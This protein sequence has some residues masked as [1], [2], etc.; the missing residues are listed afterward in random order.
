YGDGS[1]FHWDY[2]N[3]YVIHPMLLDIFRATSGA[4][5]AWAG[6]YPEAL[7][8]SQR[9]AAVQ[10]RLI[11]SAGSFP[12]IGRSLSYRSGAFQLLAQ[13]A[14][15][16]DLPEE[17]PAAQVRCALTAVIQRVFEGPGVFDEG[18]WLTIGLCGHQ[19]SLGESY[20]ST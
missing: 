10:E 5:D 11:G 1:D 2:Y 20:I 18:G 17:L 15:R 6:L 16:R 14:V 7:R 13:M 3:S 9:F 4:N 19:P 8:R 12:P